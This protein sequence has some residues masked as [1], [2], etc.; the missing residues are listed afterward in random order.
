MSLSRIWDMFQSIHSPPMLNLPARFDN[1]FLVNYAVYHH[2]RAL[3]WVVKN[4]IK[5][6]VDLLLYKRGPV[7]SHA[8]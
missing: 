6:C 3:G 7:F 8:E 5:F 1:P 2:Y 4:G